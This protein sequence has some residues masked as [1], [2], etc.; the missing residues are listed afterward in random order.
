MII[1]IFSKNIKQIIKYYFGVNISINKMSS[2]KNSI[3]KVKK[4]LIKNSF[5]DIVIT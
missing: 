1:Y 3:E 2:N 4:Y 5:N